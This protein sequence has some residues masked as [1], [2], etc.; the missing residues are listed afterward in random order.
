MDV[1]SQLNLEREAGMGEN[2]ER[3]PAEP[4]SAGG[5]SGNGQNQ[6]EEARGPRIPTRG[7]TSRCLLS[8]PPGFQP[9]QPSGRTHQLLS[10]ASG[11]TKYMFFCFPQKNKTLKNNKPKSTETKPNQIPKCFRPV[12]G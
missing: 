9:R 5:G 11:A 4:A 6:A 1:T 3:Q 7:R 12:L 2:T 10:C 8:P